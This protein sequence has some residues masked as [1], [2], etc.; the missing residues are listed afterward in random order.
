M[1]APSAFFSC[2]RRKKKQTKK[3][4]NKQKKKKAHPFQGIKHTKM[5]QIFSYSPIFSIQ[6]MNRILHYFTCKCRL[7]NFA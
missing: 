7:A 5:F 1:S 4:T 6:N 3:Q 2:I